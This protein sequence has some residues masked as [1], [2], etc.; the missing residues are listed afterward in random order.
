[1]PGS[2]QVAE[3]GASINVSPIR[4]FDFTVRELSDLNHLFQT[5]QTGAVSEYGRLEEI[6][7]PK[8]LIGITH[9]IMTRTGRLD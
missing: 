6:I 3:I 5:A 7:A 4:S 9:W 2:A 1:M 8:A